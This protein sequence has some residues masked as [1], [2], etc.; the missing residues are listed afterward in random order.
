MNR[1]NTFS[2][3]ITFAFFML[4]GGCA[5][6]APPMEVGHQRQSI[7]VKRISL[8]QA[9]NRLKKFSHIWL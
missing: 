9:Q 4:L 6:D 7:S 2:I 5:S 8:E 1:S 3:A